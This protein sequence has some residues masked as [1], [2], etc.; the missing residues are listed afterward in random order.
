MRRIFFCFGLTISVA[1]FLALSATTSLAQE[2]GSVTG[3]VTDP[4][5]ATVAG[6]DLTLTDLA[7]HSSRNT[8]SNDAGRYHF[9]SIPA[10][11]TSAPLGTEL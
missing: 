8:T 10:V 9:A 7:T 2:T 4:Q 1:A 5:G 3:V 11:V 6:A